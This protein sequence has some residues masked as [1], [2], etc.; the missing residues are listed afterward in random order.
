MTKNENKLRL[1]FF[2]TPEFALPCLEQV[3]ECANFEITAVVTASDKPSGRGL[4]LT[5]SPVKVFAEKHNIPCF[6]P[7]SLKS[8]TLSEDKHFSSTQEH[9]QDF[10]ALLNQQPPDFFVVVAYGKIIP[11]A[12]I[13][14]RQYRVVNV[15]PSLLP[16]W[17]GAA[18]IQYAL[19][20]GDQETGVSIMAL[21][22]GIDTG[23]VFAQEKLPIG[24]DDTLASLHDKLSELSSTLLVKTLHDIQAANLLPDEQPQE[25]VTYANKWDKPDCII[26][27]L[28]DTETIS[29]RVRTCYPSPGAKASFRAQEVKILKIA[30]KKDRNYPRGSAGEVVEANREEL[31][32]AAG[33][34]TYLAI[35]EM[36]FPGKSK[37]PIKEILKG[38]QIKIGERFS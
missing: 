38:Y 27:W 13:N 15:H 9:L 36:Q 25:G 4:K 7:P 10:C 20:S 23:P 8:L 37:L 22:S 35:E 3:R 5:P 19:F 14:Y 31:I 28:E 6:Q 30:M 21:D 33:K 1:V 17:R 11:D 16:R 29:R 12:L 34:D 2:A 24:H 32:I 18:P 26:N